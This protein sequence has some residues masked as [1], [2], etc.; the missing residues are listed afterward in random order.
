M[1]VKVLEEIGAKARIEEVRRV[2]RKYGKEGG[3]V[4]VK[5]GSRE[6]KREIMEKKKGLKG[7]K[8]RIED[9]LT[10]KERK[11]RWK[12]REI[13]KEERRKSGRVWIEYGKIRI[14][15]CWWKWDE[16]VGKLTNWKGEVREESARVGEERG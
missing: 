16:D 11:I 3:M 7:K 12:I 1:V 13:A 4:V 5:L 8:I 15:E 9:D 10:W 14:N 2:G 6:Q